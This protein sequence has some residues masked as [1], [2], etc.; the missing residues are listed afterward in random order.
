MQCSVAAA[1][2]RWQPKPKLLNITSIYSGGLQRGWNLN[3]TS[4]HMTIQQVP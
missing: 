1:L 3:T 4:T 2:L